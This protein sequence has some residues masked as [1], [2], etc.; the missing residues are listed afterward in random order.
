MKL[1][2]WLKSAEGLLFGSVLVVVS[3]V[4]AIYYGPFIDNFFTYDDFGLIE[5]V[6]SGP[7]AVLLGYNYIFRIVANSVWLPLYHLSGLDPRGY[8]LFSIA[9]HL[10]NALLVYIMVARLFADRGLA[11]VSS[12]FF[13]AS[14]IGADAIL[15]RA[16]NS[17]PLN[18]FHYLL[19]LTA[20]VEYR[21]TGERRYYCAALF[22]FIIAV[23][24]KE[25][26]ASLPLVAALFEVLFFGGFSDFKGIVRRTLPFAVIIIANVV[27]NYLIIYQ[28][29]HVQSELVTHSAFRPLHSL[30]SG[31]AVFFLQPDGRLKMADPRIYATAIILPVMLFWVKDRRLMLFGLGWVFLSFLPQSLSSLS[32]FEP[33]YIFNSISRHMYLPSVGAAFCYA[34]VLRDAWLRWGKVIGYLLV[35]I[36]FSFYLWHNYGLINSRGKA[37]AS[38]GEPVKVFL[39]A[40]KQKIPQFPQNT[41]FFAVNGPTGRAYMQQSLRAF[42]GN[43][44]ITWIVDPLKYVQQPGQT[45]IILDVVWL[46]ANRIYDINV[47]PFSLAELLRRAN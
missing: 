15:W 46:G 47:M 45:A 31:W 18:L 19:T 13:A 37:W 28:V 5:H 4:T 12:V 42:Y 1:L 41:W 14:A 29:L 9:L 17:T 21:R 36:A 35:V 8:N 2:R 26:S 43:P 32:Q 38:D 10:A 34:V 16:A 25:E 3:V 33:K 30:F 39:T 27:V 20:Y 7:K 23:L 22:L 11:A 6:Q 44:T 24:S 40:I